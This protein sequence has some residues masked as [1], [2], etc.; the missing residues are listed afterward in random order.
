VPLVYHIIPII[1]K[2]NQL[3]T[4]TIIKKTLHPIVCHAARLASAVLDK[5]YTLTDESEV[6]RIDMSKLKE[7]QFYMILILL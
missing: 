4:N 1:D 3:F 2:L 7:T 6:Y 5:Y